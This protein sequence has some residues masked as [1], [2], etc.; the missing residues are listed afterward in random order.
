MTTKFL[1]LPHVLTVK[2]WRHHPDLLS[3]PLSLAAEGIQTLDALPGTLRPKSNETT[4]T[5]PKGRWLWLHVESGWGGR[6]MKGP[7]LTGPGLAIL[8]TLVNVE[9]GTSGI[10]PVSVTQNRAF[11]VF[12]VFDGKLQPALTTEMPVVS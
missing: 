9:P 3:P 5:L 8:L 4:L 2:L 6:R 7:V 12:S 10:H 1:L 11:W